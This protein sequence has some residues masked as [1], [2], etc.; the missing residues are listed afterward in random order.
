MQNMSIIKKW[1]M[2]ERKDWENDLDE[3]KLTL[4]EIVGGICAFSI[5]ELIIG[6]FFA[7]RIIQFVIGMVIGTAVAII[8]VKHMY[9]T[10]D[11]A[12]DAGEQ[13]AEKIVR[14]G[15]LLRIFGI[16]TVFFLAVY[17]H[18]Y[19]NVY[20]MFI[21]V[22]NLKLSAYIQPLANKLISYCVTND[23]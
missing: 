9:R 20:A 21:S 3:S 12:I 19:I 13:G 17:L 14:N 18:R 11:R 5:L 22:F 7:N 1:K 2:K 4:Y 8:L 10:L 23:I 15:A 6:L 16:F